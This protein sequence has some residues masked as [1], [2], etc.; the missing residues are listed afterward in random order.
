MEKPHPTPPS[1][2]SIL[3]NLSDGPSSE[4]WVRKIHETIKPEIHSIDIV[5]VAG[6]SKI[7]TS[8]LLSLRNALLRIPDRIL[9][10]TIATTC[11]SPFSCVAWLV[12]DERWIA[13]D[14]RLWIPQLPEPI[15]RGLRRAPSNPDPDSN[16]RSDLT[17]LPEAPESESAEDDADEGLETF[18]QMATGSAPSFGDSHRTESE[19]QECGCRKCRQALQLRTLASIVNEWFPS[20]EYAG[21]GLDANTL[22]ELRV[23]RPEW[24]F[25]AKTSRRGGARHTGESTSPL[26]ETEKTESSEKPAFP[27]TP[28]EPSAESQSP[29]PPLNQPGFLG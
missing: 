13:D 10:R 2:A 20:W 26:P 22:I 4:I 23:T 21:A 29:P 6:G 16:S 17:R 12:G 1:H 24:V 14:A 8:A 7:E 3:I 25:G 15:L 18:L 5:F 11:L 9:V 28:S 27:P 19:E